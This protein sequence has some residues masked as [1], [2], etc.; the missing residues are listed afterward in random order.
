MVL[1]F[2]FKTESPCIMILLKKSTFRIQNA[3][4]SVK[5]WNEK[6]RI[7]ELQSTS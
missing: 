6:C 2:N 7:S 1:A 5:T 3:A 4:L